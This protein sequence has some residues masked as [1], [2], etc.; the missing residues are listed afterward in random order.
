V[1]LS[2]PTEHHSRSGRF[3]E[4]NIFPTLPGLAPDRI[5]VTIPTEPSRLLKLLT[6]MYNLCNSLVQF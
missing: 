2:I 5:V 1:T 4:E 3:G 6:E